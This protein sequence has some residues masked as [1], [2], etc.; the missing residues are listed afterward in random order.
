MATISI[1]DLISTSLPVG[2]TGSAGVGFTGSRGF[3]GPAGP[4]GLNGYTGSMG[5]FDSTQVI[6]AQTGTSYTLTST[7]PGLLI[8]FNNP[9]DVTLTIPL[10]S[11]VSIAVGQRIDIQQSSASGTLYIVGASGVILR[12][13]EYPILNYQYAIATLIKIGVNEWSLISPAATGYTGSLGYTGSQGV[14]Y[15]GS[16]GSPGTVDS[17]SG[18]TLTPVTLGTPTAGLLEYDGKVPYF[19]PQGTQRGLVPGSQFYRL[20][21]DRVGANATGAQTVF[22]VGVTLASNTVYAFEC[23]YAFTK[24]VGTTSHTISSL[25]GGTATLNNILYVARESDGAGTT[26][27]RLTSTG[28]VEVI[29]AA[30]TVVTNAMSSASQIA[31]VTLTGTVS[32]NAGGTFIPQYSLSAIPGGAYTVRAGSYMLIY[33]IGTAGSNISVGTWA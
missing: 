28:T 18:V 14:G 9:A 25:F 13:S 10:N 5:G 29:T 27:T 4:L 24:T 26:G 23:R 12:S 1:K 2:Y 3:T 15:T 32:I 8:T 17:T 6:N 16:L 21:S 11:A 20:N 30:A 33:P 22:G 19:T 31:S 7:D